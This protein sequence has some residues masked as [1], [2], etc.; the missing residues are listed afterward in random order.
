VPKPHSTPLHIREERPCAPNIDC[1]ASAPL[2]RVAKAAEQIERL[3]PR[4]ADARRE[5]HTAILEAH[6]E[7]HSTSV[8]AK[9]ARGP[10]L[11]GHTAGE[12]ARRPPVGRNP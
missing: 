4:L 2:E 6:A 11:S 3:E 7:G 8:I 9:V 5:L 12:R 10:W 1:V